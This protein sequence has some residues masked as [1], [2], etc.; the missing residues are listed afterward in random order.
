MKYLSISEFSK[1][2]N[3]PITKL[4][5]YDQMGLVKPELVKDN[6]Y[7]YYTYKQIQMIEWINLL[8]QS[9]LS[10]K[11]IHQLVIGNKLNYSLIVEK[12]QDLIERKE[13]ELNL[14]KYNINRINKKIDIKNKVIHSQGYYYK[15]LAEGVFLIKEINEDEAFSSFNLPEEIYTYLKSKNLV[16]EISIIQKGYLFKG[17]KKYYF[18]EI[19][20]KNDIEKISKAMVINI[21]KGNH[22]CIVSRI[23][24]L[25]TIISDTLKKHNKIIDDVHHIICDKLIDDCFESNNELFEIQFLFK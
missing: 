11:D 12:Y 23:D 2:T 10:V 13:N 17:M 5:Y 18:V 9:G 25:Q 14:L 24:E 8:K 16:E 15:D 3:T 19:T 4:R 7:R 21:I 6:N 22:L 20:N 1:L